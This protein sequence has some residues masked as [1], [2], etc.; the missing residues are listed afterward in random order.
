MEESEHFE[1]RAWLA[2]AFLLPVCLP[3]LSE[4]DQVLVKVSNTVNINITLQRKAAPLYL[5]EH[6]LYYLLFLCELCA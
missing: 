5:F 4:A 3:A 1:L 2:P 6:Y